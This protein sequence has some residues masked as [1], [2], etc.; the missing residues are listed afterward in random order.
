M[1]PGRSR[2][3]DIGGEE[4]EAVSVEVVSGAASPTDGVLP[5]GTSAHWEAVI[6]AVGDVSVPDARRAFAAGQVEGGPGGSVV[7]HAG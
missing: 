3:G 4:V 1:G 6:E 7:G 5:G 2:A